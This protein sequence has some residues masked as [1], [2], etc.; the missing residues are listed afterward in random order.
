MS[1]INRMLK[2][3]DARNAPE[4]RDALHREVRPLPALAERRFPWPAAALF[5]LLAAGGLA[6]L[7]FPGGSGAPLSAGAEVPAV[8]PPPA[9]PVAA[10]A[11]AVP[12]AGPLPAVESAAADPLPAAVAATP[13]IDPPPAAVAA[14]VAEPPPEPAVPAGS[15]VVPAGPEPSQRPV[16]A[17]VKAPAPATMEPK[18]PAKTPASTSA[19]VP[20]NAPASAS[21]NPPPARPPESAA[22]VPSSPP[23]ALAGIEKKAPTRPV[24]ERADADFR[25]AVALAGADRGNEAIALLLDVLRDDGGHVSSRQLLVRLLI[26]QGRQTEAMAL[27]AEGLATQ[28]GQVQWATTLARL[29]VDRGELQAAAATLRASEGFA[30][31]NA[32]YRGFSGFVAHRLGRQQEAAEHYRAALRV[33]PGEGRWWLG[34]GLALEADG[35]AGAAREAFLRARAA[36][37]LGAELAAVVDQKLR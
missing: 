32:D 15:A 13:V 27:L 11:V 25:Q 3:L 14:A 21:T 23:P 10:P 30:A 35:D 34:L 33:A 20:A 37:N 4:A 2:D 17:P 18:G 24:R 8:V 1:L 28:P 12:A 29:Q 7:L 26:G 5:A 19:S 31:T 22:A 36:G 9:P 6:Y 16:A